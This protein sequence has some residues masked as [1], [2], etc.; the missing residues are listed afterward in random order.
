MEIRASY[1][2]NPVFPEN[3]TKVKLRR[4]NSG[5]KLLHKAFLSYPHYG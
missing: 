1:A 3:S 4:E 5:L 2:S